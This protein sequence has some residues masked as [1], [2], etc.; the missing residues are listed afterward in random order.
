MPTS[1]EQR[2]V[3]HAKIK[4]KEAIEAINSF[5]ED[6]W[7]AFRAKVEETEVDLFKEYAPLSIE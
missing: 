5:Y 3:A 7:P 2:M 1:T 6:V 4:A